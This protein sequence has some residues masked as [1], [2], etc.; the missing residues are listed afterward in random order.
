MSS[1]PYNPNPWSDGKKNGNILYSSYPEEKYLILLLK[2][3]WLWNLLCLKDREESEA[4]QILI[5]VL[6]SPFLDCCRRVNKPKLD[7][8][9]E[10]KGKRTKALP[11]NSQLTLIHKNKNDKPPFITMI[12][13][14]QDQQ[15]PA[16]MKRT[17]QKNCVL[18]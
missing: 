4:V 1:L 11:A 6:N 17:T 7:D 12:D 9:K 5:L 15:S 3:A 2:L 18:H 10:I 16:E 13:Y 8:R 14:T